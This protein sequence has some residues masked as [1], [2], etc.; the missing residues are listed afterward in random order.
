MHL[1]PG[2][3]GK[4]LATIRTRKWRLA[5]RPGAAVPLVLVRLV[6]HFQAA[7]VGKPLLRRARSAPSSSPTRSLHLPS[8][9]AAFRR[10]PA[11]L[12]YDEAEFQ[13]LRPDPDQ[14]A[15]PRGRRRRVRCARARA[16]ASRA[17]IARRKGGSARASISSSASI[18]FA[19]TT[20]RTTTSRG[21]R[22]ATST[23]TG[24]MRQPVIARPGPWARRP[25][26]RGTR[27]GSAS[28]EQPRRRFRH[29]QWRDGLR[30]GQGREEPP[31]SG[32]CSNSERAS[33]AEA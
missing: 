22:T 9:L 28:A 18:T 14:A 4:G 21:W 10:A 6:H 16:A 26:S 13:A 30:T 31:R 24:S 20:S 17:V 12:G 33:F 7:A 11:Q 8:R 1:E 25:A 23:P 27:R 5:A 19:S 15:R 32:R 2:L 29:P 3:A